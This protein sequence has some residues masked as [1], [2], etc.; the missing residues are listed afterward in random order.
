MV[1]GNLVRMAR[2]IVLESRCPD[3]GYDH[4]NAS[5]SGVI[6]TVQN[7]YYFINYLFDSLQQV[8]TL[9][10]NRSLVSYVNKKKNKIVIFM[11]C[12][13]TK[14]QGRFFLFIEVIMMKTSLFNN[15]REAAQGPRGVAS[16]TRGIWSRV[17]YMSL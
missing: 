14:P 12:F 6:Q 17:Q 7:K 15:G 10:S 1:E 8:P 5:I 16:I 2:P 4:A 3:V 11:L 9:P 13:S